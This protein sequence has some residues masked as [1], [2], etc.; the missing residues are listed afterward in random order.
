MKPIV[1]RAQPSTSTYRASGLVQW[2][3]WKAFHNGQERVF[4]NGRFG[5][6]RYW[7]S[8]SIREPKRRLSTAPTAAAS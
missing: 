4:I 7:V 2:L 1:E 8:P 3:L 6:A 5:A